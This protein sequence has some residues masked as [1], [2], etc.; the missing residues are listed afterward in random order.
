MTNVI[1]VNEKDEA[2]GQKEK[3]LAHKN[4]AP[5]HRAISIIIIN[6]ENNTMLLQKRAKNKP[7]WPLFW[8]NACCTHPLP[9]ETCLACA[10]RRLQEEMGFNTPLKEIFKFIY[11]TQF[12][13]EWGEHEL[14]HIFIGNYS[15]PV[16][17]NPEEASDYKW[18]DID[19]L[20]K[21]IVDNPESYT[22]WFKII[23]ENF[24]ES[25]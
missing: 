15:G 17:L 6:K 23:L 8:S 25:W 3:L 24:N 20:K 22:P 10:E 4:P 1:L 18:M 21:D 14:D 9:E 7:T 16:K 2:V 13:T 11:N 5:L 12:D 19:E